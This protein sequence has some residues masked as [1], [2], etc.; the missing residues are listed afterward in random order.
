MDTR[1]FTLKN[2]IEVFYKSNKNTPRIALC[3]NIKINTPELTPGVEG[4]MARLLMQGT[5]TRTAEQLAEELDT[6]AIEFSTDAKA[7]YIRLKFVCLNEDFAKAVEILEDI[8]KNSTFN[9][10]EKELKKMEGE[11][12]AELDSPRTK[13]YDNYYGK[14][15][16]NHPYG[17]TSTKILANINNITKENVLKTYN[18]FLNNSKKVIAV[19]GDID[20]SEVETEI[21][22]AFQN[23]PY[24][25]DDSSKT[26]RPVLLEN[27]QEEIIKPD[28]NQAHIV[29][30]WLTETS[31]EEDYPALLLLNIILGASG[32]SSRLFL[33]L[34]DKKGLAYVVRSCYETFLQCA[35]FYIYIAT[36]PKNIE[37][38]LKGFDEEIRKIQTIPVSEEELENAKNNL[39][40][41]WA[42]TRET[43]NNQAI[44]YAGYGILNL[45]FDFNNKTKE[46]IKR[47]TPDAIQKCAQKYF[48][49][50]SVISILKP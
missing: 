13:V 47:V 43:N 29:K 36:E 11:L 7:D 16:E 21:K 9:D 37:V 39:L 26:Q 28:A 23:L 46:D 19:V 5:K 48:S 24:S 45:G 32:L 49:G 27:I 42:Y 4:L 33:E 34:R 41:K 50:K 8:I 25:T 30:G 15:F 22:N 2:N 6:Y 18:E 3:M 10:F 44:L 31:S 35:D 12:I 14:L 1:V 20:I 38:S 40:G 17:T